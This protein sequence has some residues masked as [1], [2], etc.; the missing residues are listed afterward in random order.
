[1]LI[2]VAGKLYR[3]VIFKAEIQS[4]HVYDGAPHQKIIGSGPD[5]VGED[6]SLKQIRHVVAETNPD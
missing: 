5:N 6:S 3:Y 2:R 4:W 1:M